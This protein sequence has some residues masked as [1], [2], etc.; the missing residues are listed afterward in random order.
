MLAESG[1]QSPNRSGELEKRYIVSSL[2]SGVALLD[3][4][5]D[6]DLDLY[7]V[8]GTAIDIAAD[9]AIGMPNGSIEMTEGFVSRTSPRRPASPVQLEVHVRWPSGSEQTLSYEG[10]PG[11]GG[12]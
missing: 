12:S 11:R 1:S 6:G 3:Y 8:N 2:G 10:G 7:L 9:P 5:E 4:D